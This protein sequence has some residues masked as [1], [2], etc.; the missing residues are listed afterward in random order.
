MSHGKSEFI[1]MRSTIFAISILTFILCDSCSYSSTAN[2]QK[3][4]T[5]YI[6]VDGSDSNSGKSK[7]KAWKTIE[8]VNMLDL[9]PG[10]QIRL[11]AGEKFEGT[12]TLTSEDTGTEN[13]RVTI[14]SFGGGKAVIKGGDNEAFRVDSCNFLTIKNLELTGQGR[15]FGNTSDGLLVRNCDNVVID[16]LE[17][18]G[19]QHSGVHVHQCDDATIIH[20]HAHENGFAGIHVTGT[21]MRDPENYDNHNLYIGYCVAENNPGDPTVLQNHSGNG[22]LASSVKGGII[23]YCEASDNGWDMPWTGNGPVGLWIWDCTDFIFS[24]VYHT[25]TVQI[26][27][28]LTV[29]DLILTEAFQ[30]RSFSIAL[31]II[32]KVPVTDFMNLAQPNHGRITLSGTTSVRMTASSMAV[33]LESGKMKTGAFCAIVRSTTIHFIIVNQ[34]AVTYGCMIIIRGFISGT[35]SLCTTD[36]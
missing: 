24:T 30:I 27:Q 29:G 5:Y 35:M 15:K 13:A 18:Y 28:R 3:G 6:S 7:G 2:V 19:F 21:T 34:M 12:I 10:D 20:V 26:L 11:R 16:D 32:M 33:L 8:K 22:I 14:S 23:E 36:H 9:S 31:P 17:V 1:N 25:I 4:T